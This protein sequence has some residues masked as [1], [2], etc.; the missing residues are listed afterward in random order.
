MSRKKNIRTLLH[1]LK[2]VDVLEVEYYDSWYRTK[3]MICR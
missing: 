3:L 1:E 2:R